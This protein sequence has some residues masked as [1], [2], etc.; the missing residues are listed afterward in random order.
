MLNLKHTGKDLN[1]TKRKKEKRIIR[2][3]ER[4]VS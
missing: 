1:E 3:G 4:I 2:G